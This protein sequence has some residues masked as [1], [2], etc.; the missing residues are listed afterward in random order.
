MLFIMRLQDVFPKIISFF[1]PDGMDVVPGIIREP[2]IV[3]FNEKIGAID[4]IIMWL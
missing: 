4:H 2:D 3:I 1:P